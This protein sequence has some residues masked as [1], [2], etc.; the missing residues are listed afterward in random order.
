M[1]DCSKTEN[2][3]AEKAR[4]TKT[5]KLGFCGI[6]CRKCPLHIGDNGTMFTCTSLEKLYPKDAIAIVQRWSDEHQ[7]KT[8]LTELLEKYPNV[9]LGDDGTPNF[10]PYRLGSMNIDDCREDH[11]CVKCWSQSIP[12]EDGEE[13]A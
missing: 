12:I 3:L 6:G 1:I 10:C 7:P 13:N 9:L 2:F 4:M 8:Y 11:N 5:N